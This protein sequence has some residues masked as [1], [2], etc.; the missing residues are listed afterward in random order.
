LAS[1]GG[2][3]RL[4]RAELKRI[5]VAAQFS[6][7][8][9]DGAGSP[10][11]I[12]ER[13]GIIQLDAMQRVARSHRL[14]C[15]SRDDRL[16]G[17]DGVDG[18]F[19]TTEG[20]AFAFETWAHAVCIVPVAYWPLMSLHRASTR[21]ADWAPSVRAQERL[22]SLVR[23]SG[24]QTITELEAGQAKTSGWDWSETKRAAEYLVWAGELVCCARRGSRRVYDVPERRIPA[25]LLEQEIGAQ[26]AIDGLV[27]I[28]ARAYGVAT[29][30][31]L[32]GYF[33]ISRDRV[34]AAVGRCGLIR[35]DAEGWPE[36][37]WLHPA[38]LHKPAP[39]SASVFVSPFDNLI[40]DRRR[41]RRIFGFDYVL[42]AYKPAAQR[43]Y[44]YY[45]MPLLADG[46][47]CGRADITREKRTLRVLR[48][49]PASNYADPETLASAAGRLA[50][51]LRCES[52]QIEQNELM[53]VP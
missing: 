42:E 44:G 14:V 53:E 28:A 11:A 6:P 19:W 21:T 26:E 37:A 47:I 5:A 8:G 15:F 29:V 41:T 49:F 20:A 51:Q 32:A 10:A 4:S 43:K 34:A 25:A 13:L 17:G 30:A 1:P 50:A 24:P 2:T 45:V 31:E 23:D 9:H 35:A 36:T 22:V 16:R 52:L 46:D 7:S 33:T 18:T 38:A 27:L 39:P 3:L 12:L 48:F 40:W